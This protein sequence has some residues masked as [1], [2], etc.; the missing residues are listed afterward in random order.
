LGAAAGC[1][2]LGEGASAAKQHHFNERMPGKV[3]VVKHSQGQNWVKLLVVMDSACA[4]HK[5][6]YYAPGAA[7]VFTDVFAISFH[8][9]LQ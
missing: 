8:L 6:R 2:G 9:S 4:H 7:V 1:R 5:T 3:T